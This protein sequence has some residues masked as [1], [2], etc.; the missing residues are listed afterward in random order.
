MKKKM[1]F[2][3]LVCP[4]SNLPSIAALGNQALGLADA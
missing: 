2:S 4:L 3:V 1:S